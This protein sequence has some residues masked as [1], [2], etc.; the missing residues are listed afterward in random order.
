M[1][2][3]D[4]VQQI[5]GP[6]VPQRMISRHPGLRSVGWIIDHRRI[7]TSELPSPLRWQHWTEVHPGLGN[8]VYGYPGPDRRR[9]SH[10]VLRQAR[11]RYSETQCTAWL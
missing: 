8:S 5:A 11:P 9:Q 10:Q 2:A 6:D 7:G 4:S 1:I 3:C